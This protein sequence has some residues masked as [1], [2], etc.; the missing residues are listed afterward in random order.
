[1]DALTPDIRPV[2][3]ADPVVLPLI[4]R[5]LTL[6]RAS[7]PAC[8]VHAMDASQLSEPGI[9][10]FAIL[11]KDE[12]IAMGALK[13]L[14]HNQGELKSMHVREDRRGA[15]LADAMLGHLLGTARECG[16]TRVSL[17]TGSQDAFHAARRFYERHG[18]TY[19]EPFEGYVEDPASVFLTRAL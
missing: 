11:E 18:F 8:S 4:E 6:M 1:M 2:S 9:R 15:G 19:C 7:S 10:F 3:P 17:E 13:D 5:H 16:M 12:A 14:S